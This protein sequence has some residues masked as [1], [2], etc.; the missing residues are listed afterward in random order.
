[1]LFHQDPHTP[2]IER[3][4]QLRVK[5]SLSMQNFLN[6]FWE[7]VLFETSKKSFL[8]NLIVDQINWN[9]PM[10]L[11]KL[12][13]ILGLPSQALHCL[14]DISH[15]FYSCV[16][17]QKQTIAITVVRGKEHGFQN[18]IRQTRKPTW[19]YTHVKKKP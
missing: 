12:Q 9:P 10:F 15:L 4:K 1:M 14:N 11:T 16:G 8:L 5:T 2:P 18:Q 17:Q 3:C 19:S 6:S 13:K 7:T